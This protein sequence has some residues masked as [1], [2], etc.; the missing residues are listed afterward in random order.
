MCFL[1]TGL[2][3]TLRLLPLVLAGMCCEPIALRASVRTSRSRL[4]RD[5]LS[6]PYQQASSRRSVDTE[7]LSARYGIRVANVFHAG[8]GN[9]H[10]HVMDDP[11]DRKRWKRVEEASI[12]I[13]AK[14][15]EFEGTCTGEH[16][17]GIG[18]IPF[19]NKEHGES[20][21]LMRRI[22]DLLDPD[23][24]FNPGKFF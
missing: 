13:V 10:V 1:T 22:K 17:I 19:M 20:L 21:I 3:A 5:V 24:L 18:K 6:E 15:L 11:Q 23:H 16:G 8:D 4:R 12:N 2:E 7:R 9:L 14:A